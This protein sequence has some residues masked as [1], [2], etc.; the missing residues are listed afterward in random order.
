MNNNAGGYSKHGEHERVSEVVWFRKYASLD[1]ILSGIL[2]DHD[3]RYY[4]SNQYGNVAS[5]KDYLEENIK[6]NRLDISHLEYLQLASLTEGNKGNYYISYNNQIFGI[7]IK[8]QIDLNGT[9]YGLVRNV[10][11]CGIDNDVIHAMVGYGSSL[12]QINRYARNLARK[13]RKQGEK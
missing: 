3:N 6:R 7:R 13:S 8:G 2:T 1:G 4:F 11:Y 12:S 9:N 5:R 10:R